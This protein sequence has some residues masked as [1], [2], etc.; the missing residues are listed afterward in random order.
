MRHGLSRKRDTP[1]NVLTAFAMWSKQLVGYLKFD[2]SSWIE[3]LDAFQM[4]PFKTPYKRVTSNEIR[5]TCT[6]SDSV[7]T[8]C[9]AV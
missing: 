3:C 2:R 9:P 5:Y 7:R 6:C 1:T 4:E 8:R